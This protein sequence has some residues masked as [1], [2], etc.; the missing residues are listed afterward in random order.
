MLAK[1]LVLL[2]IVLSI[3]LIIVGLVGYTNIETSGFETNPICLSVESQFVIVEI[4][5]TF[6][7][8]YHKDTKVMYSISDSTRSAG[9][10]TLL[11]DE[12]GHPLLWQG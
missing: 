2:I 6:K 7:I 9:V 12:N 5:D 8:V 11:V 1:I 10:F 3:F 4:Q